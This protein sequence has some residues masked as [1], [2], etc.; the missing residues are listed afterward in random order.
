M[1]EQL[2]QAEPALRAAAAA[3]TSDTAVTW[4]VTQCNMVESRPAFMQ[5]LFI[6]SQM[7]TS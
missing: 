4:K 6:S 3:T 7:M 1:L 2:Q 5:W